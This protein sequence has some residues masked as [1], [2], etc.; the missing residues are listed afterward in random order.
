MRVAVIGCGGIGGVVA[1]NLTRAGVE[2]TPVVGNEDAAR[3]VRENGL[4]VVEL[5]GQEWSVPAARPPVL[6]LDDGPYDLAIVATQNPALE[7]AL[8]AALPRVSGPL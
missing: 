3:A 2:V 6:A 7:G 4:R 8:R 1:A 5:D